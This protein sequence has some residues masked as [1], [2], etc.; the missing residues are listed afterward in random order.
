VALPSGRTGY[1][2][3]TSLLPLGMDQIC[4][5]KD[6]SGWKITGYESAD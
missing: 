2:S 6:A 1:V 4:Y 3:V 5:I